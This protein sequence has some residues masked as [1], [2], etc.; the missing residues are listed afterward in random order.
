MNIVN[1]GSWC[2]Q[3][4]KPMLETIQAKE[5]LILQIER[6]QE[7]RF[8]IVKINFKKLMINHQFYD[9]IFM[10]IINLK[11]TSQKQTVLGAG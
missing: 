7:H 9:I 8:G 2:F 5:A 1:P 4:F 6:E 10:T 11:K 3:F